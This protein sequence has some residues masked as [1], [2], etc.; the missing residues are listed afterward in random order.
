MVSVAREAGERLP[1]RV[2]ELDP[3]V[4]RVHAQTLRDSLRDAFFL[5]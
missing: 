5:L 4:I 1:G 3:R 2:E